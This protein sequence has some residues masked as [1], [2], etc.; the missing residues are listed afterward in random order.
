MTAVRT[1][2][3]KTGGNNAALLFSILIVLGIAILLASQFMKTNE[4][5]APEILDSS[6]SAR[7]KAS[8]YAYAIL[9]KADSAGFMGGTPITVNSSI[10]RV[11][12]VDMDKKFMYDA[13]SEDV[14]GVPEGLISSRHARAES[15][16][17]NTTLYL[18]VNATW[19]RQEL[20]EDVWTQTQLQQEGNV[21]KD[22]NVKLV[23][24]EDVQGEN[25]YVLEIKPDLNAM[26][27]HA[28]ESGSAQLLNQPLSNERVQEYTIKEW[29]STESL[30]PLK[31]VNTFTLAS[32]NITT[33]IKGSVEYSNFNKPISTELPREAENALQM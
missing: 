7:E 11:G 32:D 31:A 21:I 4:K 9:L 17:V 5:K 20:T 29:I 33:T 14:V 18:A 27:A 16:V 28:S 2:D 1:A 12:R 15:Y 8:S 25:A 19:F 23:G 22:A 13:V 30:L 10:Q 6:L 24:T 3:K 26:M